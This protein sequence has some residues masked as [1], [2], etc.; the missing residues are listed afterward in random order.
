MLC[1]LRIGMTPFSL[2]CCPLTPASTRTDQTFSAAASNAGRSEIRNRKWMAALTVRCLRQ[3]SRNTY[4]T[5]YIFAVSDSLQVRRVD[6]K[7]VAAKVVQDQSG[8]DWAMR[9]LVR[10]SM[11]TPH[12][13]IE[14]KFAVAATERASR[15]RPAAGQI[16]LVYL[17]EEASRKCCC[18]RTHTVPATFGKSVFSMIRCAPSWTLRDSL[19]SR[20]AA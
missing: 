19:T 16:S 6:A 12:L 3:L 2:S 20:Y 14:A 4:A 1:E 9:H 10:D 18:S 11:R 17:A 7:P 13:P 8:R 5:Q 15:P